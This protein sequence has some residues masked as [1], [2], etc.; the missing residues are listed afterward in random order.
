MMAEGKIQTIRRLDPRPAAYF[1]EPL[2][3]ETANSIIARYR[4]HTGMTHRNVSED[5]FG[6]STKS[7]FSAMPP[8]MDALI[9]RMPS[10]LGYDLERLLEEHTAINYYAAFMTTDQ[11]G[12]MIE[13]SLIGDPTG[14]NVT[15]FNS[16]PVRPTTFLRFCR[17]CLDEQRSQY[18]ETYWRR[19]HQ[20]PIVVV[21]PQHHCRL[22]DSTVRDAIN[23]SI[24]VSPDEENCLNDA[25]PELIDEAV[26]QKLLLHLAKSAQQ[27]LEGKYPDGLRRDFPEELMTEVENRGYVFANKRVHW[28]DLQAQALVTLGGVVG[29]FPDI[30]DGE[31]LGPWLLQLREGRHPPSTD[32][33]LLAHHVVRNLSPRQSIFGAGPWPCLNPLSDHK[34]QRCVTSMTHLRSVESVT[35]GR[36]ACECGYQYTQGINVEKELGQATVWEFGPLLEGYIKDAIAN[37]WSLYQTRKTAG[38]GATTLLRH[39]DRRGIEHPW[40]KVGATDK[41]ESLL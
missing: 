13:K 40:R 39:A 24:Y 10:S 26:D 28:K 34:G 11:R 12:E 15:G 19:I 35:Y 2:P 29:A 23:W 17:I 1:P 31:K 14:R 4:R 38:V 21:C 41:I 36:F 25:E 20:L 6:K 27:L 32:R 9:A 22:I 30:L 7:S 33:V 18:G 16:K 8:R 37:G 3:D 5:I